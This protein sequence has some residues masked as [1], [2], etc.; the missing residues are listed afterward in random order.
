MI[1][2]PPWQPA[3]VVSTVKKPWEWRTLPLPRQVGQVMG[4]EPFSAPLPAQTSH[5]PS[6]PTRI[7]A[8]LPAKASYRVISML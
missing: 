2:P 8:C 1:L 6:A 4:L 5:C 7:V 3:Q